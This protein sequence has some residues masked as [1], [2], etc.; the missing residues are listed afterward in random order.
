ML[1]LQGFMGNLSFLATFGSW[2][3]LLRQSRNAS[4]RVSPLPAAR[5]LWLSPSSQEPLI[6]EP[7]PACRALPPKL[8][9]RILISTPVPRSHVWASGEPLHS[10]ACRSRG[11][12]E[13]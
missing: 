12:R 1:L 13:Y 11:K 5:P 6:W 2:R 8:W 7:R 3:T 10:L 9:V 4:L